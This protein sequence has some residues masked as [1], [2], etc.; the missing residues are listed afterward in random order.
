MKR[1]R[2][3]IYSGA[4]LEMEVYTVD[5]NRGSSTGLPR[6]RFQ[7]EEERAA[8]KQAM[9]RRRHRRLVNENFSPSS[10]YSTLTFDQDNECHT[11]EEC[12]KLRDLF[13]RRLRR[14]YPEAVIFIYAGRGK[15]TKRF[16]IH[17][18]SEGIPDEA[19]INEWTY[20]SIYDIEHLRSHNF[21]DGQDCGCDYKGLADY[22]FEH[23]APGQGSHRW[24]MSRNAR[25]PET[26][27]PK[28]VKRAYSADRPPQAPKGYRLVEIIQTR[29]GYYDFRYVK[30]QEPAIRPRR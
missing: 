6:L 14:K 5:S 25:Q 8:H 10:L 23:W 1:V 13:F 18:L 11:W 20:G 3:K 2:R 9:S 29:Y 4:V 15:S 24:K 30:I 19:I 27:A 17:M 16:H 12:K 22:L 28:P 26:E 7:S 21:Y